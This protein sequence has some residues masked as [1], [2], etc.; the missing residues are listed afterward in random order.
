M[1]FTKEDK[2]LIKVLRKEKFYGAKMLMKEFSNKGWCLSSVSKLLKKIDQTGTVDRK[3]GSGKKRTSSTTEH[4]DAVE[5]LVQS[6]E[7]APGTHRTVRQIA[8]EIGIPKTSVHEIISKDLKL[9]CFK[10]RRAQELTVANKLTRLVRAKQLLRKYPEH[11][12]SFKW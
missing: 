7:N 3:S 9:V 5:E 1:A 6:Q 4:V 10:K 8:K 12:V 2:I 11:A